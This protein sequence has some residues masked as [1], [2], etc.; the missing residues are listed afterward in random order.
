[1]R[2]ATHDFMNHL[3]PVFSAREAASLMLG[4]RSPA[5]VLSRM[6]DNQ[7]LVRLRRGL[8]AATGS[9]DTF[10]AAN[11]LVPNSYVSFETALSH[12]GMIPE[13]V[14]TVMSVCLTRHTRITTEAGDFEFM[15]QTHELFSA[16]H[17]LEFRQG[18]SV[19]IATR[20][21]ALLDTI[22]RM[23][24]RATSMT[25]DDARRFVIEGLRVEED[26]IHSLSIRELRRLSPFYTSR[27]IHL[28]VSSLRSH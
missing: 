8:F 23:R 26:T 27:L 28:F 25:E 2:N 9:I 4:I 24:I 7:E 6:V 5:H 14:E 12:Y 11:R 3:P 20:E 19:R 18:Y 17:T 16:S 13:R 1:M 22:S 21:K 10:F 15:A